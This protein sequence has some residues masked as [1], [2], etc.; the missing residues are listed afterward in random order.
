MR[1]VCAQAACRALGPAL[2]I[3]G[4]AVFGVPAGV[5]AQSASI[6]TQSGGTVV[7]AAVELTAGASAADWRPPRTAW[8]APDLQGVWDYRTLTP[9]QRPQEFAGKETLTAEEAAAYEARQSALLDD[10]DR[11]PSVHAKWWLDYG[12]D[13]TD[14][15]RTSLLVAPPDG[16]LPAVTDEARRRAAARAERR[17]AHP[18][19]AVEDRGLTER[20]LTF[21]MPRL[22]GA[23]NNNVQIL[24]T[25]T[26]VAIVN[27]M[28]HDARIVPLDG[29]PHLS[30]AVP[31][32]H[33]DS[34]GYYEGDTLVV[35]TVN[36]SP[37]SAFR[38][39]T[40]GLHLVERF[41]RVGPNT[42][43]YAV[44][45]SDPATWTRDWTALVPMTKTDQAL[46]E[47]ACHEGN[48]GLR[49][50]LHNARYAEDPDYASKLS[51]PAPRQ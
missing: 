7:A 51:L 23:Y 48:H 43:H 18:D 19:H 14:D 31:Q 41:T 8:G 38:G 29:R 33:G 11:A 20:C 37:K 17:R 40:A 2:A 25:P 10:Y 44:T 30:D 47:Y 5:G 6:P 45:L 32:W 34:R 36:F 16:R 28:I 42:V 22:P 15:R 27:E 4:V 1:T 35:E 13:L 3:G 9:L 49:N 50:I 46:Y 12:R 24:Q 26:H 39:S 21:G